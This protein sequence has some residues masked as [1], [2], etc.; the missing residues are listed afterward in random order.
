MVRPGKLGSFIVRISLLIT[1]RQLVC[2]CLALIFHGF[3]SDLMVHAQG[4]VHWDEIT[5]G[6]A[7]DA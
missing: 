3:Y 7:E 5:E 1:K 2:K 4:M 6:Q